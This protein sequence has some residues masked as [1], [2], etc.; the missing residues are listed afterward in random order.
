MSPLGIDRAA[1]AF[2]ARDGLV[3]AVVQDV[4]DGRVL[5]VGHMDADALD[6]T[7]ATG[8]V[9]FHSRS[10]D[11]LWRKGETSGNVLRLRGLALDCDGDAILVAAEPAGPTCHRG[12]RSCFDRDDGTSAPNPQAFGWLDTL[13]ATITER[14]A[15]RPEGSYTAGLVEGGVDAVGRKVVEEATEVLIAAKDDATAQVAGIDRT[16][17]R[18]ALAGELADLV[19]HALVLMAE[20]DVSPADVVEVLEQ[21]RRR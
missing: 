1:V 17:A 9:H 13:W 8:E 15:D 19:Y 7:I 3:T 18:G 21:R 16:A 5:M 14:A 6:S 12:T 2:D 20:R 11:R 10:R 4:A